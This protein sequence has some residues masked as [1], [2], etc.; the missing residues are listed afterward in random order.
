MNNN[1]KKLFA[2]AMVTSM[3]V[4][5]YSVIGGNHQVKAASKVTLEFMCY[6]PEAVTTF[7]KLVKKFEKKYPNIKITL[8]TPPQA[9]TVL[10]ARLAKNDLP[11]IIGIGGDS[12]YIDLVKAGALKDLTKSSQAKKVSKAYVDIL[13]GFDANDKLYGIPYAGNA[14]AVIYNKGIFKKL[15]LQ[16][17]TTWNDFIKVSN[18]I[19][20]A[21]KQPFYFTIKDSWTTLPSWNCLAASIT[22]SD[23]FKKFKAGKT[24][25]K[26]AY[27]EVADKVLKLKCY[28][29]GDVFGYGYNDGNIAFAKGKAAMYL[30]GNWAIPEILKANP[31][32]NLGMF[33]FPATNTPKKNKLVSGVDLEYSIAKSC[34]HSNEA[35]KFIDFMIDK[36]NA[37]QYIKEQSAMPAVKGVTQDSSTLADLAPAINEDRVAD[38]PDHNYPSSVGA[39][40]LIQKFWHDKD[41]SSLLST[42]DSRMKNAQ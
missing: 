9:E 38:F 41:K 36:A 15:K 32:A 8:S 18:K 23:F 20:A 19:K 37:K 39:A 40:D 28:G 3:A 14:N 33:V 35:L 24:T 6:K 10:K 31:K 22:P 25:F 30:Q 5:G 27:G 17:P 7:K 13:K 16:I 26:K 1:L 4:S 29:V 2:V 21:G 12:T 42:F 34:K 11:D